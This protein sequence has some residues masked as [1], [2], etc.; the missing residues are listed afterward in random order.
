MKGFFRSLGLAAVLSVAFALFF[1]PHLASQ[2]V[3]AIRDRL[4]AD[5]ASASPLNL[6]NC[7]GDVCDVTGTATISGA[8]LSAGRQRVVRFTGAA[9]L[10][11]TSTFILP[12]AA[13]VIT[14]QAVLDI[15][16]M[17]S[18][19]RLRDAGILVDPKKPEPEDPKPR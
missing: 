4:G 18:L 14:E 8:T 5:I 2:V 3:N 19:L 12:L 9:T 6:N 7:G 17:E 15:L 10:S 16:G 1:S 11:A 13:G